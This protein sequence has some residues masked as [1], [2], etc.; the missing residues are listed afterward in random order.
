MFFQSSLTSRLNFLLAICII[1]MVLVTSGVDYQLSKRVLLDEV[2]SETEAIIADTLS[3]LETHLAGIERA[4]ALF[5]AILEQRAY[6]ESEI[7]QMLQLVVRGR[8][9]IFGTTVALDPRMASSRQGF[10]PYYHHGVHGDLKYVNLAVGAND[11]PNQT[12]FR[13]PRVQGKAVWSEPYFDEG[14]GRILMSTYSV[15]MY[16]DREGQRE[17]YGVVTADLALADLNG[18]LASFQLGQSGFALLLSQRA[19]SWLAPTTRR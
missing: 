8:S 17:F 10:A 14:G 11:Y 1:G 6:P 7:E 18:Q 19:K 3:D 12:W 15:P 4:T 5:A 9:D 13:E 2:A 16:I